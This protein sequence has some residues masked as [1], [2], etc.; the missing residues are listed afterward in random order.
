MKSLK[1]VLFVVS[2]TVVSSQ[3]MASEFGSVQEFASGGFRCN[4]GS[5]KHVASEASASVEKAVEKAAGSTE[6]QK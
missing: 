4:Q 1:W 6:E 2:A 5:L 3:A